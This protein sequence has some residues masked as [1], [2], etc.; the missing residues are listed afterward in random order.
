MNTYLLLSLPYLNYT[1]CSF[2]M[3]SNLSTLETPLLVKL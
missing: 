1:A 2:K 3:Y